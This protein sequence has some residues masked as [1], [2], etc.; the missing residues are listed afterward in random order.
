LCLGYYSTENPHV[1]TEEQLHQPGVTVWVG[2]SCK[3]VI[4]PIFLNRTVTH[5]LYLTMLRN[6]I[7]PQLRLQYGDEDFYLQQDGA[8]PHYAVTVRE[9]LDKELPHRWIGRQGPFERTPRSPD[10][11]PMDFFFWGVIKDKVFSRKPQHTIDD[12]SQFIREACQEIDNNKI[13]CTKVDLSGETRLQECV[14]M[15][16]AGNLST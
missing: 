14:L 5:S 12:M 15:M 13:L 11:T 9:F 8:P 3:G 7:I 6:T 10:L 4:G 2:F 1:T 16:K